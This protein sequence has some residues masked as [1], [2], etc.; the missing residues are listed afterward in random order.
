MNQGERKSVPKTP[1]VSREWFGDSVACML[2]AHTSVIAAWLV[3]AAA[4]GCHFGLDA[5]L[6]SENQPSHAVEGGDADLGPPAVEESAGNAWEV[7]FKD[8]IGGKLVLMLE[9]MMDAVG[10]TP[11]FAIAVSKQIQPLRSESESPVSNLCAAILLT[12]T[13]ADS[14]ARTDVQAVIARVEADPTSAPRGFLTTTRVVEKL[15]EQIAVSRGGG[16]ASQ[17]LPISD[18]DVKL[19]DKNL[20]WFG[21]LLVSTAQRNVEFEAALERSAIQLMIAL[22]AFACIALVAGLGGVVWLV[23]LAVRYAKN[24]LVDPLHDASLCGSTLPWMFAGWFIM[25]IAIA[26]ALSIVVS[27]AERLSGSGALLI[28]IVAMSLPL[29][30][31]M[32]PMRTGKSW[33]QIRRDIGLH[34]GRGV[35]RE[36]AYGVTVYATA[37]PLLV[38]GAVLAMILSLIFS[39]DLAGASHPIQKELLDG[40]GTE[41]L[42]L[43]LIAAVIAPIVEE[44]IFRGVLFRHLRDLSRRWGRGLSFVASAIGSSLIFA[45]IHPQGIVFVPILG[46]LAVAFCL[47]REMRGSLISC[48]VAHGI[49]NA[50]VVGLNI[51]L[52]G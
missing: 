3:I 21:P 1:K 12:R 15:I 24:T 16:A 32:L 17:A 48:M 7:D 26:I 5:L 27:R 11:A 30:A 46:A 40:D 2:R 51:A 9:V 44:I 22:V 52:A 18:D 13:G 23:I 35:L 4:I 10:S 43:L 8:L 50:L 25:T 39:Q 45:A 38:V 33:Q 47:A 34:S 29:V 31:V 42:L 20:P 14:E 49:N 28:T 41:R 6:Q 37:I 19:L 36:C